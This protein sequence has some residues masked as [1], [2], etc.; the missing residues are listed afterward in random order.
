MEPNV[1]ESMRKR[2]VASIPQSAPAGDEGW[3]DLDRAASVE[4]TSEDRDY[5]IESTLLTG[6]KRGWRAAK[7][8]THAIRLIFDKPQRLKRIWLAFEDTEATRTQEFVLR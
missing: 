5:P 6:E 2:V 4:V 3:L 7:P 8:G 1:K